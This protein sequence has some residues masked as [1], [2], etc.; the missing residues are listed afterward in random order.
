MT[1][2]TPQHQN[3]L[4]VIAPVDCNIGGTTLAEGGEGINVQ[5]QLLGF[6]LG[7][8]W[9][10]NIPTATRIT[11]ADFTRTA[12]AT[13]VDVW[14]KT[15][16]TPAQSLQVTG[17]NF[18]G[19]VMTAVLDNGAPTGNYQAHIVLP[20][21]AALPSVIDVVNSTSTPV[22]KISA[23]LSDIVHISKAEYNPATG[24]LCVSASSSDNQT[25]T[26]TADS[27]PL[28]AQLDSTVKPDCPKVG[29]DLT[30]FAT[31]PL[32]RA[33]DKVRVVS[34][35]QGSSEQHVTV[36][37]DTP[38]NSL[39]SLVA[40]ADS[41]L[42]VPGSGAPELNVGLND[43]S[44]GEIVIVDQ[45]GQSVLDADGQPITNIVGTVTGSLTG[46]KVTFTANPGAT[47]VATFS[48]FIKNG[49]NVSNLVNATAEIVFVAGPP[50]GNPDNFAVLRTNTAMGFTATILANDVAAF[51]TTI[52]TGSVA[53]T[54]QGT[55]GI[56]TANANGTVTY[57]PNTGVAAG[58]DSFFYTVANSVGT[59]SA[60]VKV[61]VV[62]EN[63]GES[64]SITRNRYT[65]AGGR[66]DLR[67]T[68]SWFGAPL[69]STGSCWLVRVGATTIPTPRLIGSIAL[70]ATGAAQIVVT[71]TKAYNAAN[72]SAADRPTVP[73]GSYT[74]RCGTS[75]AATPLPGASAQTADN[76]TST[77]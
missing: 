15:A 46:G 73:N 56:A 59:P 77:R 36:L 18:P 1:D 37:A 43:G 63:A 47:G 19:V 48:Y 65:L 8:V 13:T 50:I 7:Q 5:K 57:R 23:P 45:P 38:D 2:G 16:K 76:T 21:D 30:A 20:S 22:L 55:K 34:Q 61:D 68:S 69:T 70:D 60:P 49:N 29:N 32:N 52:N 25:L 71:G 24:D 72:Y 12:S 11:Q 35:L 54:T 39:P 33:P 53:I 62:V 42:A 74:I 41:F 10:A 28:T 75:N 4:K 67:M 58:N 27:N 26:L 66:W 14:A 51:G 3:Y 31:F 9:T 40:N 6:L 64:I 17:S 44:T